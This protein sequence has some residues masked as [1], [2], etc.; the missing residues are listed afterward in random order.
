MKCMTMF[1][2]TEKPEEPAKNRSSGIGRGGFDLLRPRGTIGRGYEGPYIDRA[3][4]AW[5]QA[6]LLDTLIYLDT[7]FLA[8]PTV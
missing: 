4:R 7:K 5:L 2:E 8:P 6:G 1:L 3:G